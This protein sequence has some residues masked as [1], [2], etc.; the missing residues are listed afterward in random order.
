M[1]PSQIGARLAEDGAVLRMMT[2]N[3]ST[4]I[5]PEVYY[6]LSLNIVDSES[7]LTSPDVF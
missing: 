1:H 2:Q 3:M 6:D 7:V 4:R 5:K